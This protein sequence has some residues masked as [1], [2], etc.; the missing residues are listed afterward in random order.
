MNYTKAGK[1]CKK[2]NG[3][4]FWKWELLFTKQVR[5]PIMLERVLKCMNCGNVLAYKKKG[6]IFWN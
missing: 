4:A 5:L 1:H 6:K 2:C 3:S